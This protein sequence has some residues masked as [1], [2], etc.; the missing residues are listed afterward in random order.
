MISRLHILSLGLVAMLVLFGC[1]STADL[2]KNESSTC[3][4]HK[5]AMTIQ[6][7][8]CAPGGFAGYRPEYDT[9]RRTQFP[10]HGRIHFSGDDGYM[11]ARHLRI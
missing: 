5:C 9:A 10:H 1:A 7:V 4:V 2:T 6:V 3:D 8:D 11:Y